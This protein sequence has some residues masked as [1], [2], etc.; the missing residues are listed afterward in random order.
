MNKQLKLLCGILMILL[1]S[2]CD[3]GQIFHQLRPNAVVLAFGDS[4]TYGTGAEQGTGYPH[5]LEKLIARKVINA[6]VPGETSA[7]GARRLPAVLDKDK[8]D[9]LLLCL[10]GNDLLQNLD[11]QQLKE[12][13]R[14]MFKAANQRNIPVVMIAVP[15]PGLPLHD[16]DLYQGLAKKYKI[17]LVA[18]TL[19]K[20]LDDP[21]YK[22]DEVHLNAAG[23]QQLAKAV[24]DKLIQLDLL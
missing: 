11:R 7:E 19:A 8:P 20:L 5:Q 21:Q 14:Q 10:G 16:A 15:R 13:L 18:G 12:N 3:R 4:L 17:P 24:A 22:S 2:A 23:Y 9:L 6:G 1:L